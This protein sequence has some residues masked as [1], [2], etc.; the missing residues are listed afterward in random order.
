M[1]VWSGEEETPNRCWWVWV[2]PEG[3]VFVPYAAGLRHR[4]EG[5]GLFWDEG[6]SVDVG[7]A[8]MVPAGAMKG[9][10]ARQSGEAAVVGARHLRR[11]VR[12]RSPGSLKD[13]ALEVASESWQSWRQQEAGKDRGG[14]VA[15][16]YNLPVDGDGAQAHSGRQ[17]IKVVFILPERSSL[18][19]GSVP[20]RILLT[21]P[22]FAADL[23]AGVVLSPWAVRVLLYP[24]RFPD[25]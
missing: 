2:S 25:R 23:V 14:G 24:P 10:L 5:V 20:L 11:F 1:R 19:L 22:A 13:G 17:Q 9:L 4:P 12:P 6:R 3:D 8:L 15:F 16:T 21:A 18:T 7:R